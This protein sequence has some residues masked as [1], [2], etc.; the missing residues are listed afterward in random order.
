M[1]LQDGVD[2]NEFIQDSNKTNPSYNW[3][4][5]VGNLRDAAHGVVLQAMYLEPL[6]LNSGVCLGDWS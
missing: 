6:V 5:V 1:V 3:N 4:D 2:L